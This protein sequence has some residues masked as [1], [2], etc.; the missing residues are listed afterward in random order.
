[1]EI[2]LV[3]HSNFNENSLDDFDRFQVV[4]NCY[5]LIDGNLVLV[6][7]PFTETWDPE[8]KRE[9]TREILSGEYITYCAFDED[10]VVGEIMLVPEL[11]HGR[12]I[13]DSF[14]VSGDCRRRGIG[15]A[16]FD[17]AIE[18]GRRRGCLRCPRLG[19]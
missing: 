13:V 11:D 19:F 14:H 12:L 6:Y 3:N 4:R 18:E 16:L 2:K 17:V 5:R 1:M 9:K 7:H 8:R 15:R 10:R